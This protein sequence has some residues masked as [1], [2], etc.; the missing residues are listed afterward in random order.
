MLTGLGKISD[1]VKK[2]KMDGMSALAITDLGVL[3]GVVDLVKAC[4][5]Q[6]IKPIIGVE[7]FIA[8]NGM[9][10]K[11]PKVDEEV[12]NLVLLAETN[13]GYQNLLKIVSAGF[14][15]GFYYRPRIDYDL[16]RKNSKGLIAL[17]GSLRG[18][19][20]KAILKNFPPE[21]LDAALC[22]YLDIFGKDNFFIEIIRHP[23]IGEQELVNK[24]LI[25]LA[26]RHGVEIVAAADS[27]YINTE[28]DQAHDILLCIKNNKKVFE[29]GRQTM[30]GEDYSLLP[31]KE[32]L[33]RFG[34]I[35]EAVEN[36]RKIADRC[37]VVLE[38]GVN[39]L[40]E[41]PL[42]AG[43]T[44]EDFLR[45]LCF[46]GFINR[47]GGTLC[48]N[49]L[50]WEIQE[51]E[52]IIDYRG[53]KFYK[54]DLMDRLDYELGVINKTGYASYFLIVADFINWAKTNG[55]VVGPGRG[56]A[57]GSFVAYL[58]NI[59]DLDPLAFD[60]LFERFLNPDRISMPDI[61]T[62]F[63]DTGREK[64][65][66]YVRQK[67]GEMNVAGIITFGTLGPKAVIRDVGR[68]MGLEYAY[69]DKIS[70]L[71]PTTPGTQ[72]Q[73][74]LDEI[75][76][77][78][79]EYKNNPMCRQLI[80]NGLK[81]EGVHRHASTH[82]C[83]ILITKKP[84]M[85]YVPLQRATNG[86]D[87][88]LVSQYSLDPVEK[89]G[90]LK[91]D[92]LGLANL[93][94]IENTLESIE[95]I[96]GIK[97]D[98]SRLNFEDKKSFEILQRGEATG[99]F[100]FESSGMKRYLKLLKP[101]ELEDIIA[102][103]ALYRPGPLDAGMVEEFID[104]KQ[105]RKAITYMHP[106][107]EAALKNTYGV[108]VY[109][110]QVMRIARDL[111][112]FTLGQADIMRKA[113]GKKIKELMDEQET[114]VMGGMLKN[115]IARDVAKEIW[116][117]IETF[118]RYGFN[119]S[120]AACY[121][122]I[123]YQTAYLKANYPAEF[124]ASLLTSDL[125]D[126]DRIS[127]EVNECRQMGIEVMPPD[128]N[129]SFSRFTVVAESLAEGKPRIRF[130]LS[131]IKGL[132]DNIARHIIQ[133]RKSQG[134]Y[135]D[136]EDF[137]LRVNSKELNKKSLDALI[138][139]GALDRFGDRSQMLMNMERIITFLHE[140]K[141]G[142][143][144]NQTSLFEVVQNQAKPKLHMDQI[145]QIDKMTRLSWEKE[146]MGFYL[147]EHPCM[148]FERELAGYIYNLDELSKEKKEGTIR[149]AG[150]VTLI[151]KIV[152]KKGDLMMFANIEG[153]R[154]SI[155]VVVFPSVYAETADLWQ[156]N[157]IVIVSG[158][159]SEKEGEIK[160]LANEVKSLTLDLLPTLKRSLKV[161]DPQAKPIDDR[162][163][164]IFFNNSVGAE[165][166]EQ[167][168]DIFKDA[169]GKNKVFLAVPITDKKFRKIETNF[170]VDPLVPEV[171]SR[172]NQFAEVKFV[173]MM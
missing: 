16:L 148:D 133:E 90:L 112:G 50:F 109:Q 61:D 87:E 46:K 125:D 2:A 113:M 9:A 15:D 142:Q 123:S 64:V 38:F 105:G 68:A 150:L 40:P 82:A 171:I 165:M 103:G 66:Q 70:K 117:Q 74:S 98:I 13:E 95:K 84:L 146:L 163:M 147:S 100:Q 141:E 76:D 77:L 151:K 8:P 42:P 47:Y 91:M 97:I 158:V 59:T 11:R 173:K 156:E 106:L 152:T 80:D 25:E 136:L 108:I 126:I 12:H 135:I 75:P 36:T 122:L 157:S 71:I 44:A 143:D 55:I 88:S 78:K 58:A 161:L 94:I 73:Q 30:M 49:G 4:G 130:G 99:I 93:T 33:K 7:V 153:T 27:Y 23:N 124:M 128:V 57:A 101:T 65:I 137:L 155:E 145:E 96:H 62:D 149:I 32:M 19:I 35:P 29:H 121:G 89:L 54:K 3:Y 104:R 63:A 110:E 170:T 6:G 79:N 172:I 14:L 120:H 127:I 67:Y 160:V 22:Q 53:Q 114:L 115:G 102:M 164:V 134:V 18:E 132:G 56:S 138:R 51:S 83:G 45:E 5:K 26:G 85:E 166:I 154:G 39:K 92:F 111:A 107:L 28:D 116:R 168:S 20:P 34:D 43:V 69:C 31:T 140:N 131:A 129:E 119:R 159:M 17:S 86:V 41:F 144:K 21:K 139:S 37:N 48:S 72:L 60:L 81:L 162:Q 167:L 169:H 118:A 52:P 1:L 10:Q 24:K